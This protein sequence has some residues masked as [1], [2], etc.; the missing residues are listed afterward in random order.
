MKMK[1]G[2]LIFEDEHFARLWKG[3]NI[4]QFAIPKHFTPEWLQQQI[5]S[6]AQKKQS[7]YRGKNKTKHHKRK[8]WIV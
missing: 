3:L 1:N 5:A 6:L 8:W 4:L 2:K 7:S